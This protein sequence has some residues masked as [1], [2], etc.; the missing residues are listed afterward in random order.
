M[1]W[2]AAKSLL[3][4]REQI[5]AIA[6]KRS[7]AADGL[8]GDTAHSSRTSDHNPD[9]EDVVRAIDI[10]HDPAHGVNA[11][12]IAEQLRISGDK[13]IKY[14]I[15]NHR[16]F[17]PSI[18]G[19]WRQYNGSNPHTQHFHL[20]VVG[21]AIADDTRP[22]AVMGAKPS[23]KPL[24]DLPVLKRGSSG[25]YVRRLQQFLDIKA[26]G[27]FGKLT[28]AAVRA[29]QAKKKLVVDG[30]V[31]IYTWQALMKGK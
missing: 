23:G 17:T 6:P 14:V 11:G 15:S 21:S 24:P 28:D 2:R 7:K 9:D 19:I 29:F 30:I 3:T 13:R 25:A 26:D 8:V 16:I 31:G 1:P 10:T 4:L 18:S 12:V 5:N 27:K 22:W 20:S